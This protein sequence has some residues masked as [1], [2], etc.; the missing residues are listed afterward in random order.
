MDK[1]TFMYY[2]EEEQEINI[3]WATGKVRL[4]FYIFPDEPLDIF[5]IDKNGL[6]IDFDADFIAAYKW[7]EGVKND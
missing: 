6:I 3:T 5:G 7:Y 2:N 1:P 4:C